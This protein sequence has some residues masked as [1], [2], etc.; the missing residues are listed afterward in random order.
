MQRS[1]VLFDLDGVIS[2][3][4]SAHAMAWKAI[5]EELLGQNYLSSPAIFEPSD[6]IY[7]LDGK[8][9]LTGIKSYL[10]S[11]YI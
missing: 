4:A 6:Y 8:A 11:K 10:D 1:A 3:T 7:Y 9:R 5:L 2:D